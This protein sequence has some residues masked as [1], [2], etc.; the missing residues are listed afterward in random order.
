MI[1]LWG[2]SRKG[3]TMSKITNFNRS[4][5]TIGEQ[6][7]SYLESMTYGE[8]VTFF[9][10]YLKDKVIPLLNDN[11]ELIDTI[12][13]KVSEIEQYLDEHPLV[14]KTSELIN[15]SG[16]ITNLVD[17]LINYYDKNQ[18]DEIIGGMSE[19]YLD[20]D[21]SNVSVIG[22]DKI[23]E[24]AGGGGGVTETTITITN[25][26]IT[27]PLI[28]SAVN[29]QYQLYKQLKPLT[30]VIY[31]YVPSEKWLIPASL[32]NWF[33]SRLSIDAIA[34]HPS[35]SNGTMFKSLTCKCDI[36]SSAGTI[37]NI[38]DIS[39]S[40]KRVLF[41]DNTRS[42]TPTS[43]YNPAT[44]KYVDDNITSKAHKISTT[45]NITIG[46]W[47]DDSYI[48]QR[49]IVLENGTGAVGEQT[50]S[51]IN[52]GIS[53]VKNIYISEPSYFTKNGR[54]YGLCYNGS[55]SFEASVDAT[56]L[57]INTSDATIANSKMVITLNYT[58]N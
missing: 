20:V 41:A 30:K 26:N 9:C 4:H 19:D 36:D 12:S 13:N 58:L 21:L 29:E 24:I 27:D 51:L 5:M 11:T 54:S 1:Y 47:Y 35:D 32:N 16:F 44:K 37:T 15:D 55:N 57:Y 38:Y 53:N 33:A 56:N 7:L 23:K 31:L 17:D 46:T 48:K 6:P 18:I 39:T 45:S 28:I 50:F 10:N 34:L 14:S 22:E 43:N 52:Y 40:N 49:T 2:Y 25:S 3:D 8:A 42:F